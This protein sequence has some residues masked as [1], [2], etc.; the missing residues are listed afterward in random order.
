MIDKHLLPVLRQ[1][2]FFW[3]KPLW[4]RDWLPGQRVEE[5]LH[6]GLVSLSYIFAANDAEPMIIMDKFHEYK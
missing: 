6:K 1:K 4:K 3:D 2:Y 5:L